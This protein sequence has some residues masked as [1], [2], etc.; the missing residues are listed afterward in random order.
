MNELNFFTRALINIVVATR[1]ATGSA[2]RFNGYK[3]VWEHSPQDYT[4]IMSDINYYEI[5]EEE[6]GYIFG[7]M[8]PDLVFLDKIDD[9]R[10]GIT[11]EIDNRKSNKNYKELVEQ[12]N[13]YYKHFGEEPK[14]IEANNVGNFQIVDPGTKTPESMVSNIQRLYPTWPITLDVITDLA[15]CSILVDSFSQ[16]PE[17][18][19]NLQPQ[20]NLEFVGRIYRRT[21][22]YR[23]VHINFIVDGVKNE[24]Q[25]HS[26]KTF[27]AK[28]AEDNNYKKWRDYNIGRIEN[29]LLE[30]KEKLEKIKELNNPSYNETKENYTA[31]YLDYQ[32]LLKKKYADYEMSKELYEAFNKDGDFDKHIKEIQ[33][34]LDSFLREI[35]NPKN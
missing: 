3:K 34:V 22:G 17:I 1:P 25:F 7:D 5:S 13:D 26:K 21:S 8:L 4:Q 14:T 29:E 35:C 30:L 32:N 11:W 23:A 16:V 6:A 33:S 15:R 31:K 18:L 20:K 10:K 24:I 28:L 9:L 19:I 27:Q 2:I 12:L